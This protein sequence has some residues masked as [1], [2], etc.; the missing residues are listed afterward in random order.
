MSIAFAPVNKNSTQPAPMVCACL[1]SDVASGVP[2]GIAVE[3]TTPVDAYRCA[4]TSPVQ[5]PYGPRLNLAEWR[6]PPL[7]V[8]DWANCHHWT[9]CI[10]TSV[11]PCGQLSV[12]LPPKSASLAL[13]ELSS[14]R[15]ILSPSC[16]GGGA[17]T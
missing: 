11:S 9:S 14:H 5:P 3:P 2:I 10:P 13:G 1:I 8:N 17:T 4:I 15:S 7:A 12:S 16:K 6:R